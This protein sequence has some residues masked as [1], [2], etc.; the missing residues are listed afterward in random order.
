[1]DKAKVLYDLLQEGGLEAH[2]QIS[3]TDK[4]MVPVFKKLCYFASVDI[5][6]LTNSHG[7]HSH[8]YSNDECAN[9]VS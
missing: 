1:M 7:G 2:K 6:D 9:L 5:F 8:V 4:D 3:A